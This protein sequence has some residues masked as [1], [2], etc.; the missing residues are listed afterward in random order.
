MTRRPAPSLDTAIAVVEAAL[1]RMAHYDTPPNAPFEEW[2]A[3]SEQR[4]QAE[5]RLATQLER[6]GARV[7]DGAVFAF[8][9]AGISTSSTSSFTGALRNW[10]RKARA[11]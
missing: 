8:T 2:I 7:T 4:R 11:K 5:R 1:G 6:K 3:K 9:L 10:L